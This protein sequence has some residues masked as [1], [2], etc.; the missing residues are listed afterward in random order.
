MHIPPATAPAA[1]EHRR[2]PSGAVQ[3]LR[4]ARQKRRARTHPSPDED[5]STVDHNRALGRSSA[6]EHSPERVPQGAPLTL[7]VGS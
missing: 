5:R 3:S 4:P 2:L 1:G 7:T 6:A